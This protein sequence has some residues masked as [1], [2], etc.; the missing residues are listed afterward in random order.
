M[1]GLEALVLFCRVYYIE[2]QQL[3][4]DLYGEG[5]QYS[6]RNMGNGERELLSQQYSQWSLQQKTI[7]EVSFLDYDTDVKKFN[8]W[9]KFICE[10]DCRVDDVTKLWPLSKYTFATWTQETGARSLS[11]YSNQ[12]VEA[13]SWTREVVRTTTECSYRQSVQNTCSSSSIQIKIK[14][15]N[16]ERL[17]NEQM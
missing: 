14:K 3:V 1:A 9:Y 6:A 13:W 10:I 12:D 8:G 15:H 17:D 5:R 11:V 7:R 16:F 4:P 2:D